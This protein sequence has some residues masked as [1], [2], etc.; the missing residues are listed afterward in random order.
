[1]KKSLLLLALALFALPRYP[2]VQSDQ[3]CDNEPE[4]YAPFCDDG[5]KID[6]YWWYGIW[7]P[8]YIRLT[9]QFMRLPLLQ[10]GRAVWYAP[11]VMEA[12]APY[13]GLDMTGYVGGVASMSCAD[14]G[15][16]L[17][18]LIDKGWE[19]PFLVV[20][21]PQLDDVYGIV[22][23]REEVIEVSW[24]QAKKWSGGE[25]PA[26]G[27]WRVTVSRMDPYELSERYGPISAVKLSDWYAEHAEFYERTWFVTL[28]RRPVYQAPSTWRIN[29]EWITFM[30]P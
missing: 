28:D 2:H 11:G 23:G 8:G 30:A 12:Q 13:R 1:M 4:Y 16:P 20:D 21:C 6:G 18:V 22:V 17:W 15:L 14:M 24:E 3:G 25:D 26:S 27:G 19:G 7:V 9:S 29:G 10:D 5:N